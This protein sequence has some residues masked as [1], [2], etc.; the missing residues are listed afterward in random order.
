MSDQAQ[1]NQALDI[2]QSYIVQAPAGSGKTELL[3]QRYLKLLANC[4]DPESVIAMTFTNKA[5]DE[6]LDRVLSALKSSV[7]AKPKQAH[8][9]LTH[10]LACAV[11]QRS[12]DLNWQLLQNSKRLKILTIDGLSSLI[13]NRYPLRSQ[14]VPRKIMAQQWEQDRAYRYAAEQTLLMI[15]DHQHGKPIADLLLYLDN[16]VEKFYRLVMQMLSKR[17]QWLRRLYR[18]DTMNLEVLKSSAEQIITQYLMSLEVLA[19]PY[20][21]A[22]FFALMGASTDK[23]CACVDSLPGHQLKDLVKWQSIQKLCLN[24][25][26]KWRKKLD[27]NTGFPPDLKTQKTELL[28]L[29]NTLSAHESLQEALQQVSILPDVDFSQAQ[30]DTLTT[31]AEV[32]KL[33]VAQLA[34]YFEREQ[35][36][37]FIEVGLNANQALKDQL[38]VSDAVL[39]LDYKVQHLLIDEFQDTSTSQ[40]NTIKKLIKP[41]Q[42]N[43]GKTLF[44]VGDPMQ[45]IYRFRESQVGLFLQVK[46]KGIADIKP[47]SLVLNAN[48]RSSKSIVD[49]NN[50]FFQTIFPKNNDIYQGAISYSPSQS[51]SSDEDDQAINFYPFAYNQLSREAE[52]V[53]SIVKNMLAS[54]RHSDIAILVR[55]RS[56]LQ[57]IAQQLTQDKIVFESLKI[58]KLKEHLLTRDLFSLTKALLHLGDKLAWLSVLRSPWCGLI[59]DDLLILSEDDDCIIYD[60]LSDE[61]ILARLSQEGRARVK[62]LQCCLQDSVNNQG[63]FNF[64]ELLTHAINQLGV[65]DVLS[66]TDSIIKDQF[67]QIIANCEQQQSL[68][69]KTIESALDELYAPSEQSNVKLMTIHQSKGLEFDTVIIPGLGG[70]P[71]SDDSPMMHMKEFA[72]QSLLLAPVKSSIDTVESKIYAYLKFVESQQNKFETMRL[73]YVAMTRAKRKL[74]LMGAVNKSNK[75]VSTSLLALLMQ[76]YQHKFEDIDDT[77]DATK[78]LSAPDLKRFSQLKAPKIKQQTDG[79]LVEYQQSFERLFKSLLGTLVH[80]YYEYGLFSPS[81]QNIRNRLIEIGMPPNDMQHWQTYIIRL[82]DNTKND[83]QF[84][85]LFKE[86]PSTLVEAEFVIGENT[87]VIDR[88][89]IDNDILW[90]IDFKTAELLD[91]ESLEQFIHRQQSKHAEQ[92]LFYK[93]TLSNIYNNPIK[94]ALYCPSISRLIEIAH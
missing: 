6:M 94:C 10:Q 42:D 11:M 65:I 2:T 28:A 67:L 93:E 40:F 19:K 37:D 79:E 77:Q 62:H 83:S 43:E 48:F 69:T 25:S 75:A 30:F 87:I 21:D 80:Q 74:H 64:I 61:T 85:W 1:R 88:L 39:F 41:W 58:T 60:K 78:N 31:I 82:L 16:N 50:H 89:F 57:K 29:F 63:R 36:H 86:R 24:K 45:S 4:S 7:Q 59:L 49:G 92:L 20:L 55:N 9:Q 18:E 71:K 44:I 14:L 53:S 91:D 70:K 5:V 12:D 76:F 73:L 56:H 13:A 47:N 33:C 38:G 81:E 46:N 35:V 26:G 17:D 72:D 3:T 51:A 32:L 34:L 52:S 27:K 90:V 8:K 15:D 84:D 22:N 68:D 66:K 23:E 54:D